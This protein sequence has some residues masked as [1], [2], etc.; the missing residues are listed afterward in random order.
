MRRHG[1]HLLIQCRSRIRWTRSGVSFVA[2]GSHPKRALGRYLQSERV[3]AS[4]GIG[5]DAGTRPSVR[6]DSRQ[7]SSTEVFRRRIRLVVIFALGFTVG[8]V[9]TEA[10]QPG[11]S[12]VSASSHPARTSRS[13]W[14]LQE[15]GWSEGR[16]LSLEVRYAADGYD[17]LPSLATELVGLDVDAIFAQAQPAVQ[18]PNRNRWKAVEE[19]ARKFRVALV[20]VEAQVGGDVESWFT[21]MATD[22]VRGLFV[23]RGPRAVQASQPDRR[24]GPQA[25]LTSRLAIPGGRG[26]RR[27]DRIR[28]QS[29]RHVAPRRSVC[30]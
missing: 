4:R 10:Q 1:S 21:L 12:R 6:L 13:P 19:A 8:P 15:L 16:N 26:C 29:L 5:G 20:S 14:T 9:S 30:R 3:Q 11:R 2:A 22:R 24:P 25:R 27:P 7:P 23:S 17:R 28:R 18:A